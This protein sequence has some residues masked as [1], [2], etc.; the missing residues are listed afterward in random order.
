MDYI[1]RLGQL[2]TIRA[3]SETWWGEV[4][5]YLDVVKSPTKDGVAQWALEQFATG[6]HGTLTN[7][8]QKWF[9]LVTKN[10]ELMMNYEVRNHIDQLERACYSI[11]NDAA[12][13]FH[14]RLVELYLDVGL[15]GTG[16]MYIQQTPKEECPIKFY[17]IP[18]RQCYLAENAQENIDTVYRIIMMTNKNISNT[19]TDA[20]DVII[21]DAEKEPY[22][23]R[24]I[25]HVVEPAG[26]KKEGYTSAFVDV[27]TKTVLEETMIKHFPYLT[28]RWSKKSGELYGYSP[29]RIALPEIKALNDIKKAIVKAIQKRV[30]PPLLLPNDTIVNKP[31]FTAG[32][33]M[34]YKKSEAMSPD[35][36]HEFGGSAD[37][38]P[39]YQA[40]MENQQAILRAFYVELFKLGKEHISMTATESTQRQTEQLRLMAPMLSRFESEFLTPLIEA[41]IPILYKW[42]IVPLPAKAA[43]GIDVDIEFISPIAQAQR[44]HEIQNIVQFWTSLK[45]ISQIDQSVLDNVNLDNLLRSFGNL[46]KVEGSILKTD[47]EVAALRQ[48]RQQMQQAQQQ[49][50]REQQFMQQ[51]QQQA[52]GELGDTEQPTIR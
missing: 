26:K 52:G 22:S 5:K 42:A 45:D 35:F 34:Y 1:T 32:A 27:E 30:D 47:N 4:A 50:E 9:S 37:I 7:P 2:K 25:L 10:S 44:V 40:M 13:N 49:Q 18:I 46:Y 11:F 17:T 16:V 15:Y 24:E 23:K 38:N 48:Q 39:A 41:T 33:I 21:K 8:T 29:S 31:S 43:G 14:N 12:S 36:I 51:V 20:P 6:L 3:P 19:W 28:P